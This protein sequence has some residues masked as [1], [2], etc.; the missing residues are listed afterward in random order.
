[1]NFIRYHEHLSDSSVM[2][3]W[4]YVLSPAPLNRLVMCHDPWPLRPCSAQQWT[5]MV[6]RFRP[7]P[8]GDNCQYLIWGSPSAMTQPCHHSWTQMMRPL[9][10]LHPLRLAEVKDCKI[11][12][13]LFHNSAT[14][15]KRQNQPHGCIHKASVDFSSLL[16]HHL[17]IITLVKESFSQKSKILFCPP[18][19]WKHFWAGFAYLDWT[20]LLL[21]MV[22]IQSRLKIMTILW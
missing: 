10:D 9:Q 1:M 4:N 12:Q 7:L 14:F 17:P 3:Y 8:H 21:L 13:G 6:T 20:L 5:P 15:P 18:T 2:L 22:I 19:A 16:R 11:R